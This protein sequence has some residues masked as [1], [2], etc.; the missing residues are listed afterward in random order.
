MS[1]TAC[2]TLQ[3]QRIKVNLNQNIMLGIDNANLKFK[4]HIHNPHKTLGLPF[5]YVIF[6]DLPFS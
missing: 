6:I 5:A 4:E 1:L 2:H 3:E